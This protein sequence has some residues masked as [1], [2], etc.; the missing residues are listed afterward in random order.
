M[1]RVKKSVLVPFDA[2]K[3]FELVDR[4]ELYP[5]FLPWCG[6][7][8]VLKNMEHHKTAR[9]DIDYHGVRAH[10]T[11]D[12]VN[13]RPTSIVVTLK[14]GPFRHLHGEWRFRALDQNACKVEFEL[15]YEFATPLLEK[16]VGPVFNHIANTFVD[17]FVRRAE[18]VYR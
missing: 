18:S 17:A 6:G 14:S 11:T 15:A 7:T 8:E 16:I 5:K 1:Q 2:E 9:I 10:F 3:M 12:N 13:Y 4:V